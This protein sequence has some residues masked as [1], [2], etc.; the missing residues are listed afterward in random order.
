MAYEDKDVSITHFPAAHERDGAISYR[1][2]V[3]GVKVVFSG[4]SEPTDW[5]LKQGKGMD[6]LIHGM[7]LSVNDW[8]NHQAGLY[9]GDAGYQQ[10]YDLMKEIQ[11]NS[12]TPKEALGETLAATKPR[13]GV[14]THCHFNQNTLI[15]AM[16]RVRRRYQ[17]PLAWTI[18]NMVLNLRPGQRI[19]RRMA[20]TSDS[21][22]DLGT[23]SYDNPPTKY[24]GPYAAVQRS[25][26][27]T[28]PAQVQ[29][30]G[31]RPVK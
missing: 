5:M 21:A 4:D 7:A 13:L 28:H 16:D 19:K 6:V 10:V 9:P 1:I 8:V 27:E 12:H 30:I 11:D 20:L 29:E 26:D 18:D 24:D 17:G 14:I 2:E 23:K 31:A 25:H 3:S 15:Q 22:R